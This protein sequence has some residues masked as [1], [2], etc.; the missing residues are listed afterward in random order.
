MSTYLQSQPLWIMCFFT[1]VGIYLSVIL[2]KQSLKHRGEVRS[3][4]TVAASFL[5]PFLLAAFYVYGGNI[6]DVFNNTLE[7]NQNP[8]NWWILYIVPE[9][10]A[11]WSINILAAGITFSTLYILVSVFIVLAS[12]FYFQRQGIEFLSI[13]KALLKWSVVLAGCVILLNIN[14]W[15]VLLGMGAASIVLGFALKEMLE[16][17]F[18]GMALDMEGSFHTGDW[19]RVGDSETVGQV[20]EKNWRSTKIMTINDE[21][22][23]IPNRMLGAEKIVSFN[24]PQ[25]SFARTLSVGASYNDPPVKVKEILRTILNREPDVSEEPPPLVRTIAY[26]DFSINYE[27]K[28]WIKAHG[29]FQLISDS[30]MTQIWYA[31]KFYGIQIPFPIRTL[32]MNQ[33]NHVEND[34]RMIEEE[35]ASKR[36]FLQGLDFFQRHLITWPAILS[37]GGM[38][39]VKT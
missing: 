22:I 39:T 36:K 20:Y 11:P 19:I 9:S 13:H 31:F 24:K 1:F 25:I 28:F 27:M 33:R 14:F 4:F 7:I 18:T 15:P 17:L 30:I 23:T 35:V 3:A 32:H 21:S 29:K 5:M 16:N 6:Q 8:N 34:D 10:G 2:F 26:D 38:P 12:V 37:A